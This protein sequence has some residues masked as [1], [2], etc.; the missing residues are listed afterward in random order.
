MPADSTKTVLAAVCVLLLSMGWLRDASADSN[1]PLPRYVALRF[2]TVNVRAGP[3]TKYP[4]RWVYKRRGMPVEILREVYNWRLV[5][6]VRGDRGWIHVASLT[7]R[8]SAL[9]RR[10]RQPLRAEPKPDAPAVAVLGANVIV[11]LKR[12]EGVW[13]R[14]S[15]GRYSGWLPRAA[16]WGVYPA[17]KFE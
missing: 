14:V 3:G 10:E 6:D 8:R 1:R 5:R 11:R 9:V 4:I 16:L 2:E 7:S 13:C 12:C 17:E 15:I